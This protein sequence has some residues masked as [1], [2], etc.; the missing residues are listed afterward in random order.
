MASGSFAPI[1]AQEAEARGV[2]VLRGAAPTPDEL[3]ALTR[4]AL[5]EHVA[6]R[7]RPVAGQRFAL[8][9]AAAAHAAIESRAT[10]GKTLLV[11]R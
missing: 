11:V 7:L 6:A 8:P 10:L 2:A 4:A 3:V 1:D 9:D 5:Q